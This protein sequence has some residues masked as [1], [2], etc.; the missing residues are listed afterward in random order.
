MTYNKITKKRTVFST[1]KRYYMIAVKQM[2][3]RANI[4]KYFDIAFDYQP[5]HTRD[6]SRESGGF[7]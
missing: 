6:F 2:D 4:K 1:E 7:S 5:P 3:L